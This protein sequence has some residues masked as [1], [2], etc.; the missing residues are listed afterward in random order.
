MKLSIITIN[1]NNLDGL[2]K[3]AE[4]V[5]AQ[6]WRDFEWIIVDGGSTD[7]SKE[8]I[9]SLA[10]SLFDGTAIDRVQWNV[11]RFSLPGF[12][13]D[14][15][16]NPEVAQ[17]SNRLSSIANRQSSID[18]R[19]QRFLWCSEPDKGVYNAQNK[20][21]TY[22]HGEFVV[23]MNSGDIFA[24]PNTLDLVLGRD[25]S[26]DIIFG[27]MMRKTID[28]IPHNIPSMKSTLYWEDF[29]FDTIPHQSSYIR[30]SLF[31]MYGGYDESYPRLADWKWFQNVIAFHHASVE[32]IPHKLSVY[33]CGG[34]SED[35][36]WRDDLYRMRKETMPDCIPYEDYDNLR[37]IHAISEHRWAW[38]LYRCLRKVVRIYRKNLRDREF[39][40]VRFRE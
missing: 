3:T 19:S 4:S 24:Y 18:N 5:L 2:K 36:H 28:G 17:S 6:T 1:Y 16:K 33:E 37:D 11:E 39:Y 31:D 13:A 32:F 7:G 25:C 23:F 15:L 26:A 12:T 34:I 20:G 38:F 9:E 35:N 10:Q 8:Y 27:Y 22:S 14:D 29:Y 30:R 40:R 21:L